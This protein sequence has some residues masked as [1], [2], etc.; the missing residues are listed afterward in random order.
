MPS[1]LATLAADTPVETAAAAPIAQVA[2]N[3]KGKAAVAAEEEDDEEE[4]D[5]GGEIAGAGVYFCKPLQLLC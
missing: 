2:T 5:E 1:A 4:A 3:G